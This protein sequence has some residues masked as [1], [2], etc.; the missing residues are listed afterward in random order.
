MLLFQVAIGGQVAYQRPQLPRL[1]QLS[2]KIGGVLDV[3]GVIRLAAAAAATA[4]AAAAAEMPVDIAH[5]YGI[6]NG[7]GFLQ[8]IEKHRSLIHN[9]SLYPSLSLCL[10][11]YIACEFFSTGRDCLCTHVSSK[12]GLSVRNVY[13]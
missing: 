4:A 1:L 10:R 9:I 3:L 12:V 5:F 7:A 11:F 13:V 6:E 2:T 8:R